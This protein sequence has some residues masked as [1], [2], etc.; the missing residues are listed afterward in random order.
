MYGH[1][2]FWDSERKITHNIDLNQSYTKYTC[3]N[4]RARNPDT[5]IAVLSGNDYPDFVVRYCS[6]CRDICSNCGK[7]FKFS[8]DGVQ[9]CPNC[10][11]RI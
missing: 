1:I 4:C 8:L 9:N 11:I 2:K 3:P 10:G 7:L 5:L 6:F